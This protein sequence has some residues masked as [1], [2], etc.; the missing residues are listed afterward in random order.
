[1]GPLAGVRA[2]VVEDEALIAM[3][4]VATLRRAGCVVVGPARRV[5][6]A[7]LLVAGDPRPDVALLDVNLG[8]EPVVPVADALAGRD[9]PFVLI[10]GYGR[11]ALPE[12]FRDRPLLGKPCA[13]AP[14]LATLERL[15]GR[16]AAGPA[17]PA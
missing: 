12:R 17:V 14:L 13:A 7:L 15:V 11:D 5:A 9:I 3:D 10:T 6:P 4:L 8:G 16:P 1:M 2:L